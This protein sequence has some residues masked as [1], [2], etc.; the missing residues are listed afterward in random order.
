MVVKPFSAFIRRAPPFAARAWLT[1]S[2]FRA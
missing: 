1:F 2:A